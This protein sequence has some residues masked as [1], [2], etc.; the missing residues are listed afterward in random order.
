MLSRN[1]N[2]NL[3]RIVIARAGFANVTAVGDIHDDE[4]LR[5]D[6]KMLGNILGETIQNEQ[7]EVFRAIETMRAKSKEWRN[8]SNPSAFDELVLQVKMHKTEELTGIARG[9]QHFLALSNVAENHHRIR[10]LRERLISSGVD[11]PMAP[12]DDSISGAIERLKTD[13]KLNEETIIDA[14]KSQCVEVVLTA[15]PTEVNRRTLLLKHQRV[16]ELLEKLDRND[17]TKY[18]RRQGTLYFFILYTYL[19]IKR[20]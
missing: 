6:I 7:P 15:H 17:L 13:L 5:T 18:D 20:N 8:R 3:R 19:S 12:R 11:L 9:F 1:L 10:R 2:L 14:L 16:M 4:K